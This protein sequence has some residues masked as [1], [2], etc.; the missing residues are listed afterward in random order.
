MLTDWQGTGWSGVAQI[1]R[2]RENFNSSV[3]SIIKI[4]YT[5]LKS[6]DLLQQVFIKL[7]GSIISVK[8]IVSLL[9][10]RNLR[11]EGS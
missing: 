8:R 6:C 10:P 9:L 2:G 3:D 1:A 7:T 4:V 5:T 11:G